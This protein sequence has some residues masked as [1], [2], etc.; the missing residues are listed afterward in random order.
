LY[1]QV[2]TPLH[3]HRLGSVAGPVIQDTGRSEFEDGLRSYV[4][5]VRTGLPDHTMQTKFQSQ[6]KKEKADQLLA[7]GVVSHREELIQC[8]ALYPLRNPRDVRVGVKRR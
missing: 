2:P 8:I 1:S 6:Q 4:M 7:D 5:N 3:P